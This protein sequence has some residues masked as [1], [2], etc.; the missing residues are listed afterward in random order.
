MGNLISFA[1]IIGEDAQDII[2]KESFAVDSTEKAEWALETAGRAEALLHKY[3]AERDSLIDKINAVFTQKTSGLRSTIER[4]AFLI[5]PWA[6]RES[7]NIGKK[8]I[9]LASGEVQIRAGRDSLAVDDDKAL[10]DWLNENYP[11]ALN[12]KTTITADKNEVKKIIAG[13][14]SVPGARIEFG[15]QKLILKPRLVELD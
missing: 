11:D 8:T 6:L 14:V 10:V 9:P 1:D 7:A 13:G 4:M 5:D 15:S 3:E 2:E 12:V